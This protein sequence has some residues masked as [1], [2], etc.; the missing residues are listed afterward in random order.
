MPNI[1]SS[2]E[3][4]S[5]SY[6]FFFL[7]LAFY[8]LIVMRTK[9]SRL[10]RAWEGTERAPFFTVIFSLR[11]RLFLQGDYPCDRQIT[12][13]FISMRFLNTQAFRST[14]LLPQ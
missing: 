2:G 8:L 3:I 10:P 12:H 6:A 13:E 4:F 1:D 5:V 7:P 9:V 11:Q 14:G